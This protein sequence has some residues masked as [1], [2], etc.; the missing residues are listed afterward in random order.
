LGQEGNPIFGQEDHP[1][2]GREDDH[3]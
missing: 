3:R 2:L 1:T